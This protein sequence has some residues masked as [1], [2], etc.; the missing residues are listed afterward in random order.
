MRKRGL[1]ILHLT[2]LLCSIPLS[3]F[4]NYEAYKLQSKTI[5][6]VSVTITSDTSEKDFESITQMLEEN[7]IVATF[8]NIKRNENGLITSLKI[9]LEDTLTNNRTV[10]NSSS[11]SPI[12]KIIFGRKNGGLFVTQSNRPD[13]IVM[14]SPNNPNFQLGFDRDSIMKEYF[15]MFNGKNA[16]NFNEMQ[17]MMQKMF[18]M[19]QEDENGNR[20]LIIQGFKDSPTC[21]NN[22]KYAFND[23]N[24]SKK[25]II[26]NG[27]V[28]NYKELKRLAN[29]DRLES[30]D[31]L[32][33]KTAKSIY[34]EK[35][36]FGAI[37]VTTK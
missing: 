13:P 36:K 30:I 29:E 35:G 3:S 20:S 17:K 11:N 9:K 1:L 26:I 22:N 10:S 12:N 7:G 16:L 27:R 19:H 6:N 18:T 31:S 21:D 25:H 4:A 24:D 37:I 23:L 32:K 15:N 34:G 2:L 28:S 33:S 8:S 14:G 5:E